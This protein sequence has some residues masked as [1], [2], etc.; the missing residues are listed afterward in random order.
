MK[1]LTRFEKEMSDIDKDVSDMGYLCIKAIALTMDA[2]A[3]QDKN[4]AKQVIEGDKP[5]DQYCKDIEQKTFKVLLLDAPVAR[6][7]KNM[8]S[9]LKMI[10]DLERIGDYCVDIAEEVVAFP[11]APY[12]PRIDKIIQMGSCCEEML[13]KAIQSYNE[14]DVESARSLEK[15]DDRVDE[16]F[17]A[18]KED[19]LALLKKADT[20][21]ADQ[22]IIFMMI[23][24]YLERIGDHAVNIGEWVDFSSTGSHQVS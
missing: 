24:K 14:K 4:K 17:S 10:T 18:E 15:D 2:F 22:T 21:Y 9:A 23:A 12:Y 7:F 6:D 3:T 13:K 5:I 11:E 19:L 1:T 20:K 8:G 16:L